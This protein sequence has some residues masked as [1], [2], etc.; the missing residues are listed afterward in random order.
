VQQ[1]VDGAI[2]ISVVGA[3]VG[4]KE[5]RAKRLSQALQVVS[6]MIKKGGKTCEEAVAVL[7]Q[8]LSR[9]GG[10]LEDTPDDTWEEHSL[11][12]ELLFDG[13]LLR[14]ESKNLVDYVR[15]SV[16]K[17]A[18]IRQITPLKED[19]VIQY[20]DVLFSIWKQAVEKAPLGQSGDIPVSDGIIND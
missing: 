20:W 19:E 9:V 1:L 17:T 13:T 12:T 14:A 15:S 18:I 10:A 8:L 11:L 5:I 7:E 3:L 2:G 4:Q 16:D 6:M